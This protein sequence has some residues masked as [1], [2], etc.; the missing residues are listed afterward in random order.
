MNL[1]PITGFILI[2]FGIYKYLKYDNM[3][4]RSFLNSKPKDLTEYQ[5]EQIYQL[6]SELTGIKLN[7]KLKIQF[8]ED[9]NLPRI[10]RYPRKTQINRGSFIVEQYKKWNWKSFDEQPKPLDLKKWADMM[11]SIASRNHY[12]RDVKAH[13]YFNSGNKRKY[14]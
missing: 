12:N 6:W 9:E 2:A 4:S 10:N 8:F 5:K 1:L 3:G 14:R 7:S 13:N 11:D